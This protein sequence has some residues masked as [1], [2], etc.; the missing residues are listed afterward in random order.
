MNTTITIFFCGLL[1]LLLCQPAF[2]L[3]L[4]DAKAQGLVGETPTGYLDVVKASSKAKQL[5]KEINA[6]RKIHYQQ[7]AKK[8]KTPL[9]AVEKLAGK[10]ALEKT[11]A[12]QYIKVGGKWVKK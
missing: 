3:E 11:P 1:A 9:S 12:G 10:K 8:N 5:I 2:A 6:K 4:S 7:I